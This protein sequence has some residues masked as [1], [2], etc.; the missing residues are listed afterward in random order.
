[1]IA[2]HEQYDQSP[3]LG[4]LAHVT[5]TVVA[6]CGTLI[7]ETLDRVVPR[8]HDSLQSGGSGQ[9]LKDSYKKVKFWASETDRLAEL[10]ANLSKNTMR[11]SML[12]VLA[13]R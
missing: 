6:E 5:Q 10:Q 4:S 11:L 1:M 9:K 7:K 3:A 12:T 8:Y 13:A 2:V